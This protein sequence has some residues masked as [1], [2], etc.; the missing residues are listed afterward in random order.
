MKLLYHDKNVQFVQP[1]DSFMTLEGKPKELDKITLLFVIFENLFYKMP[2]R[3]VR[4]QTASNGVYQMLLTHSNDLERLNRRNAKRILTK[5][6]CTFS[7]VK[8]EKGQ[9]EGELNYLPS[10]RKHEG[11]I[12]NISGEGC[13]LLTKLP[14][15]AEQDIYLEFSF[16]PL[17]TDSVIGLICGA[18]KNLTND[19]YTLHIKFLK[20]S[21][22]AKNRIFAYV[23][24]FV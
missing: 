2:V 24:N 5:Q 4:Y 18:E 22:E 16:D 3:V 17:H 12:N 8:V 10:D 7:S 23:Y 1:S 14:I 19:F 9:K 21:L 13:S 6:K 20:I 15:K 11:I